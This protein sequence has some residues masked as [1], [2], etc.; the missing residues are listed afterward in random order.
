M[1]KPNYLLFVKFVVERNVSRLM[2]IYWFET[3]HSR[4]ETA[5]ESPTKP[6]LEPYTL[7]HAITDSKAKALQLPGL[8]IGCSTRSFPYDAHSEQPFRV[9][10]THEGRSRQARNRPP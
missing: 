9:T 10:P 3:A 4:D 7:N 6:S 2:L 1:L 8:L 5:T